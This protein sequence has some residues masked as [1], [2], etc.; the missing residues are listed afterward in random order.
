LVKDGNYRGEHNDLSEGALPRP[1]SQSRLGNLN[2]ANEDLASTRSWPLINDKG[3]RIKTYNRSAY[4]GQC[5]KGAN[6]RDAFL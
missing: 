1:P 4:T 2:E 5:F 3:L 6:K